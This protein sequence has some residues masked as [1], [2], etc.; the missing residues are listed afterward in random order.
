MKFAF[1]SIVAAA[2]F[3]A[4]GAASAATPYAGTWSVVSG[5]G[6]LTFSADALGALKTS[7]SAVRTEVINGTGLPGAGATNTAVYTKATG[8]VALTFD[9]A[10][11]NG[12][13]LSSLSAANSLVNIRRTVVEDGAVVGT[14]NVYMSNF[15]VDLSSSTIFADLYSDTGSLASLQ[16]YGNRSI[17]TATIPGVVGGTQGNIQVTSVAADGSATGTA[18]GGLAGDLKM[19]LGTA[20]IILTALDLGT[21]GSVADL[22]KNAKWGSTNASGT[23]TAPAPIPEPSTYVL[24]GLGLVAIGAVARRRA[25]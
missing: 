16:S 8:N 14:L 12:D 19:N 3:V 1:K 2:A 13:S 17:F 7:G 20:D 22:V 24:M 6:G 10:S 15:K 9:T 25:A 5:S 11:I 23:F 4:V 21:T 18:S